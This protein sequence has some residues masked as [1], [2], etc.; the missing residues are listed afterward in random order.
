MTILS[1]SP[2]ST[3]HFDMGIAA[4]LKE[5]HEAEFRNKLRKKQAN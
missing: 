2:T 4:A 3:R 1:T 5:D